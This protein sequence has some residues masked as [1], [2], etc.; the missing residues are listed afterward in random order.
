MG[1]KVGYSLVTKWDGLGWVGLCGIT[2]LLS[3]CFVPCC[4]C[5][6]LLSF[7]LYILNTTCLGAYLS[8]CL[9][10]MGWVLFNLCLQDIK[11]CL[12][13]ISNL[14]SCQV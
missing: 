9:S 2:L 4:A 3:I 6:C 14:Y 7:L 12:V 11:Y 10:V 1:P 8:V 13:I 5:F